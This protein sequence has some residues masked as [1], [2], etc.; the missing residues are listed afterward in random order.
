MVA[1]LTIAIGVS[2][3]SYLYVHWPS[4]TVTNC[5][6][7]ADGM[8]IKDVCEV[9]GQPH[10]TGEPPSSPERYMEWESEEVYILVSFDA[11]GKVVRRRILFPLR[12]HTP[13]LDHLWNLVAS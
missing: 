12:H 4:V 2:S 5:L 13:L 6:R 10:E 8:T 7:I 1:G 9:L 3:F 11:S